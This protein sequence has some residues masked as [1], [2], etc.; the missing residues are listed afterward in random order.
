[1]LHMHERA[2]ID[3]PP[4]KWVGGSFPKP[5]AQEFCLPAPDHPQSG[6]LGFRVG[7]NPPIKGGFCFSPRGRH[8]D[9]RRTRA[10]PVRYRF[11]AQSD[12]KDFAKAF[13]RADARQPWNRRAFSNRLRKKEMGCSGRGALAGCSGQ[14]LCFHRRGFFDLGGALAGCSGGCSGKAFCLQGCS[15]GA[16]CLLWTPSHGFN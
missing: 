6:L 16:L 15:V 1:M 9:Y 13:S 11:F 8:Q 12:Y 4:R 7:P 5:R 10:K 14:A 3:P 2:G